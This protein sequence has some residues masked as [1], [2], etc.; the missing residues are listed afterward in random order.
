MLCVGCRMWLTLFYSCA[1]GAALLYALYRW[2]IPAT[3]QYHGG[4]ALIWHDF[5]VERLIN[6]LTRSSRPQVCPNYLILTSYK[7]NL[8]NNDQIDVM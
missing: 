5:I 4:L 7:T 3:V 2:V 6:T 1:G 8:H